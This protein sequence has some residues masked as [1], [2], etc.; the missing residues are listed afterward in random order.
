[1]PDKR[2]RAAMAHYVKKIRKAK[3]NTS[4]KKLK[5]AKVHYSLS[6]Y[7]VTS[8]A[9][10]CVQEKFWG[11]LS[12]LIHT[13]ILITPGN[14]NML[15][16]LMQHKKLDILEQCLLYISDIPDAD[17]IKLVQF[18]ISELPRQELIDFVTV[19]SFMKIYNILVTPDIALDYALNLIIH[20]ER[21]NLFMQQ[22]LKSLTIEEVK[23]FYKYLYRWF[24]KHCE[25]SEAS[26]I[27]GSKELRI[28][29]LS[30]IVDWINI[31][32][33]SH[34]TKMILQDDLYK[35]IP[36][37]KK[38][39]QLQLDLCDKL[40]SIKGYMIHFTQSNKLPVPEIPDYS[41]EVLKL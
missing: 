1:M 37:F 26:M 28:P 17:L 29:S 27:T 12:H 3:K 16:T 2:D 23:V 20:K 9:A 36:E 15:Q 25:N 31:F 10:Y 24:I 5:E 14:F 41:I 13:Q 34:F 35:L 33:D 40:D 6:Q 30:R 32:L 22:H 11:P 4:F 39:T 19:K 7:F 38:Y 18:Y 8:V 21:N